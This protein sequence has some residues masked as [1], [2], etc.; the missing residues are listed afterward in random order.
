MIAFSKPELN[1]MRS[2][3]RRFPDILATC[4]RSPQVGGDLQRDLEDGDHV[5]AVGDARSGSN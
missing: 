5:A 1:E 2:K 3:V 4:R